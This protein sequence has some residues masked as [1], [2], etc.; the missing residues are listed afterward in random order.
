MAYSKPP[1]VDAG[2]PH[3]ARVHDFLLGGRDNYPADQR[4][5]R[6]LPDGAARAAR[7][8]RAFMRR[9]V[10]WLA[11]TGVDQFL[12]VGTGI[13]TE[14]NLHQIVQRVNPAS[15]V[16]YADNDPVVLRYAQAR[17][18]SS[19]LGAVHYVHADV[20]EPAALLAAARGL[21]DLGRPAAL[22]LT[23]LLHFLPDEDDPLGL[24]RTLVA[25]LAAGSYVVLSHDTGDFSGDA[26]DR[27]APA[28]GQAQGQAPDPAR[29]GAYGAGATLRHRGRAD[30][31]RFFDGLELVEPGLVAA[32]LWYKDT[33][34]P[35][36]ETPG[37]YA[38]VARVP[39]ARVP[40]AGVTMTG[41]PGPRHSG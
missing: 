34:R 7:Q 35:E 9:A 28:Q 37:V 22:T 4:V 20:R 8:N 24:T 38:G 25:A 10:G 36:E 13:P 26:A 3:P 17:L 5:A 40:V 19:P 33:P 11:S 21:L 12:D 32:P 14:P 16:V 31:S 18:I 1:Q 6:R 39:V 15:R 27:G 41:G 30:V 29:D 23:A 2:R